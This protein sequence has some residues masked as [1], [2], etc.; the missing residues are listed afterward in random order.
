MEAFNAVNSLFWLKAG[1]YQVMNKARRADDTNSFVYLYKE[2]LDDQPLLR[3]VSLII[4]RGN[5]YYLFA[6]QWANKAIWAE[7]WA[8]DASRLVQP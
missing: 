4:Y 8:V 6:S 7:I 1:D 2:R 3:L 5:G